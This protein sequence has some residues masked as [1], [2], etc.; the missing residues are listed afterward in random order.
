M[1]GERTIVALSAKIVRSNPISLQEIGIY[2]VVF[3]FVFTLAMGLLRII[4]TVALPALSS[5]QSNSETFRKR[6]A[7]T[8]DAVALLSAGTVWFLPFWVDRSSYL[9]LVVSTIRRREYL[10]H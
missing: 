10:S 9:F 6:F 1:H 7:F 8:S 2:S 5:A 4:T 3:G